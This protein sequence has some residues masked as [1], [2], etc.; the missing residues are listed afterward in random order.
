L[1]RLLVIYTLHHTFAPRCRLL[2]LVRCLWLHTRWLLPGWLLRSH[3]VGL[4]GYARLFTGLVATFTLRLHVYLRCG[5]VYAVTFTLPGLVCRH[6]V[7]TRTRLHHGLTVYVCH[8]GLRF[9][10]HGSRA[11]YRLRFTPH[12]TTVVGYTRLFCACVYRLHTQVPCGCTFTRTL[13]CHV[14]CGWVHVWHVGCTRLRGCIRLRLPRLRFVTLPQYVLFTHLLAAHTHVY[15]TLHVVR[16]LVGSFVGSFTVGF[17]LLLHVA[18]LPVYRLH[19]ALRLFGYAVGLHTVVTLRTRWFVTTLRLVTFLPLHTGI[20]RWFATFTLHRLPRTHGWLLHGWFFGSRL[21]LVRVYAFTFGLVG[22]VPH[23]RY[24]RCL[25]I[26][27]VY[28]AALR[29]TFTHTF[30]WLHLHT[31]AVT[32]TRFVRF[33]FTLPGSHARCRYGCTYVLHTFTTRVWLRTLVGWLVGCYTLVCC[34]VAHICWRLRCSTTFTRYRLPGCW[35]H[36]VTHAFRLGLLRCCWFTFTHA[37]VC[38]GC[39]PHFVPLPFTHVVPLHVYGY[40]RLRTFTFTGYGCCLRYTTVHGY[41]VGCGYTRFAPRLHTFTLHL[42]TFGYVVTFAVYGCGYTHGCA[43]HHLRV[44]LVGFTHLLY[45]FTHTHAFTFRLRLRAFGLRTFAH[46]VYIHVW[47]HALRLRCRLPVFIVTAVGLRLLRITFAV[48]VCCGCV[49]LLVTAVTLRLTY[50]AIYLRLV[51][52]TVTYL[53]TRFVRYILPL[54]FWLPLVVHRYVYAH[55]LRCS[56]VRLVVTV[57]RLRLV[58]IWFVPQRCHTGSDVYLPTVGSVC[59]RYTHLH[60]V[61][62]RCICCCVGLYGTYTVV[63]SLIYGCLFTHL[64]ARLPFYVCVCYTHRICLLVLSWLLHGY[65]FTH[66]HVQLRLRLHVTTLLRT[67]FRPFTYVCLRYIWLFVYTRWLLY[68]WFVTFPLRLLRLLLLLRFPR[69]FAYVVR[70]LRLRYVYLYVVTFTLLPL[71]GCTLGYIYGCPIYTLLHPLHTHYT[72]YHV[73]THTFVVTLLLP[74]VDSHV[75]TYVRLVG[76][77]LWVGYVVVTLLYL[78]LLYLRFRL[79]TRLPHGYLYCVLHLPTL[80]LR[81]WLYTFCSVGYGYVPCLDVYITYFVVGCCWFLR[82]YYIW[83]L[84]AFGYI[85]LRCSSVLFYTRYTLH[86]CV[87]ICGWFVTVTRYGYVT[88]LLLRCYTP[89]RL[90]RYVGLRSFTLPLRCTHLWFTF[91]LVPVTFTLPTVCS[92]RYRAFV[93]LVW[94]PVDLF[95][96]RLHTLYTV[97]CTHTRLRWLRLHARLLLFTFGCWLRLRFTFTIFTPRWFTRSHVT[98]G[99]TLLVRLLRCRLRV[100]VYIYC[101]LRCGCYV[102]LRSHDCYTH[103]HTFG[104]FT[105]TF[106]FYARSLTLRFTFRVYA[107][108]RLRLPRVRAV[109]LPLLP[110]LP[111]HTILRFYVWFTLHLRCYVCLF[112]FTVVFAPFGYFVFVRS[113][114]TV[115]HFG[116]HLLLLYGCLPFAVGLVCVVAFGFAF[117][118]ALLGWVVGLRWVYVAVYCCSCPLRLHTRYADVL[119][120]T[121]PVGTFVFVTLYT[122]VTFPFAC[123][124]CCF[125]GLYVC[126]HTVGC[127]TL[128]LLLRLV[129]GLVLDIT[130]LHIQFTHTHAHTPVGYIYT[131]G[132]LLHTFYAYGSL[133]FTVGL[134]TFTFGCYTH[135]RSYARLVGSLRLVATHTHGCTFV[136][137]LVTFCYGSFVTPHGFTHTGSYI[138]LYITPHCYRLFTFPT[139]GS[140]LHTHTT[141]LPCIRYVTPFPVWLVTHTHAFFFFFGLV[142]LHILHCRFTH[143][144]THLLRLHIALLLRLLRLLLLHLRL[145]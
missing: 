127:C 94:V 34:Y 59:C 112:D 47:S 83:Y 45:P 65:R 11:I 122:F 75:V 51:T 116:S 46:T 22:L 58:V 23:T 138:Y 114:F 110:R 39:T 50:T 76:W 97:G 135:T 85:L 113:R 133:P 118:V 119:L 77:F 21:R 24:I 145:G 48:Y 132:W 2:R 141:H 89:L 38:P 139:H 92:T 67:P 10:A 43:A 28:V 71:P 142:G 80:P 106:A 8:V 70:C 41:T 126:C 104:L 95:L 42:D 40:T 5:C 107:R 32:R 55:V 137:L 144:P 64:P 25:Y 90:L 36:V 117:A 63:A 61:R 105:F 96:L 53:A 7:R 121:L 13:V 108:L 100:Y 131:H 124:C 16:T 15:L 125:V 9:T 136:R 18:G 54:R 109:W 72:V 12:T 44:T 6:L 103:T 99:Y 31:F 115:L 49:Y 73:V 62:T 20:L 87:C 78:P 27:A 128:P 130:R 66:T 84:Y 88:Q 17:G 14:C 4:H 74:L 35:L 134:H 52:H 68:L 26:Y 140:R 37:H 93:T 1:L 57:L 3:Y 81:C 123:C 19:V 79:V 101:R 29:V 60:A 129:Y 82:W 120:H 33:T 30:C 91:P 86:I 143:F 56:F 111:H 69:F 102:G 98:F